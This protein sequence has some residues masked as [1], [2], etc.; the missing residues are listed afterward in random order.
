[1]T[2]TSPRRFQVAPSAMLRLR[3]A[4]VADL[5]LDVE[6]DGVAGDR[7]GHAHGVQYGVA[8]AARPGDRSS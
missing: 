5:P 1:M 3:A 6:A 7:V 2:A 4:R 8:V